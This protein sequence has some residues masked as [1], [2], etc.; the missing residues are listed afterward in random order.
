MDNTEKRHLEAL[1][2]SPNKMAE[3]QPNIVNWKIVDHTGQAIGTVYDVLFDREAKKARYIVTNLNNGKLLK[4]DRLVL[5]PV[6]RARYHES[7]DEVVFPNITKEQLSSLPDFLTVDRLTREDEFAV[8]NAFKSKGES[9]SSAGD[10]DRGSFYNHEDFNEDNFY[11]SNKMSGSGSGNSN[12]GILSKKEPV[13]TSN[14]GDKAGN[15][16]DVKA[17]AGSD[18]LLTGT[19][20]KSSSSENDKR[21]SEDVN[22]HPKPTERSGD[23]AGADKTGGTDRDIINADKTNNERTSGNNN[24]NS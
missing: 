9:L 21:K 8:R 19:G 16:K 13:N 18:T 12:T 7:E 20:E 2:K 11:N 4:Q 3:G 23:R 6:G 14:S 15:S 10:Q 5:M 17:G 24:R 1:S 22:V